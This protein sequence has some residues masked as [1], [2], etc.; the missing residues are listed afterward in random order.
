MIILNYKPLNNKKLN[1]IEDEL[2]YIKGKLHNMLLKLNSFHFDQKR[3]LILFST[4]K[5]IKIKELR[6]EERIQFNENVKG[7]IEFF[8]TKL[9]GRTHYFNSAELVDISM[10]GVAFNLSAS[11]IYGWSENDTLHLSNLNGQDLENPLPARIR[12]L[13]NIERDI[14]RIGL[15]FN[16]RV[17]ANNLLDV[18]QPTVA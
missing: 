9:D 1:P 6:H 13:K 5:E 18:K 12:Y 15:S 8:N 11:H 14:Y 16:D 17:T 4:P 2:I 7:Y 10:G 3:N